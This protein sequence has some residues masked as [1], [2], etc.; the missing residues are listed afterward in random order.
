[1]DF[2]NIG[3]EPGGLIGKNY[4]TMQSIISQILD[5]IKC[6]KPIRNISIN[7]N[8]KYREIK[9]YIG[10]ESGF[11][12]CELIDSYGNRNGIFISSRNPAEIIKDQIQSI[13]LMSEIEAINGGCIFLGKEKLQQVLL[14]VCPNE[15]GEKENIMFKINI[16]KNR[17][18][19][20]EVF[21]KQMQCDGSIIYDGDRNLREAMN[22]ELINKLLKALKAQEETNTELYGA[23]EN[24]RQIGLKSGV[25]H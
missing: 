17:D 8:S 11:Y 7:N 12:I 20:W 24:N 14:F 25:T 1:M 23:L 21:Y 4:M 2:I 16:P 13:K 22:K 3:Q 9:S 15:E 18:N 6:Q 5:E 19:H 10:N